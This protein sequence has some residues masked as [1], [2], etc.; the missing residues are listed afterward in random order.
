MSA[1]SG[2]QTV[3]HER[4]EDLQKEQHVHCRL[5]SYYAYTVVYRLPT[6]M[7]R[8]TLAVYSAVYSD[9]NV[10]NTSILQGSVCT[11]QEM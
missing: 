10:E 3:T 9:T 4:C 7:E 6:L 11:V 8:P 2:A 1:L 5:C